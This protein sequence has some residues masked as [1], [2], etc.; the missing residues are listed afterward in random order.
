[1]IISMSGDIAKKQKLGTFRIQDDTAWNGFKLFLLDKGITIE[2]Y[3]NQIVNE[4]A[5]E[6]DGLKHGLDKFVP[7]GYISKPQL[8]DSFEMKVNWLKSQNDDKIKT[9]QDDCYKLKIMCDALLDTPVSERKE[10]M[11]YM[12]AWQ[13]YGKNRI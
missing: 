7:F 9:I 3:F 2:D 10:L 13:R 8:D 4:K 6:Y 1:M 5:T 12:E 11:P